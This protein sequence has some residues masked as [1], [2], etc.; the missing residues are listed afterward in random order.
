MSKVQV[1]VWLQTV[2]YMKCI[3]INNFSGVSSRA[4]YLQYQNSGALPKVFVC[5]SEI[6]SHTLNGA[7][8]RSSVLQ[9]K[10]SI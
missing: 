9:Q 3:D 2:C 7:V 6:L 5:K 8:T 4:Q 1:L 10:K